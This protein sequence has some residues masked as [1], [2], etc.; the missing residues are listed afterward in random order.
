MKK[1]T[2]F[3]A[4]ILASALAK[5]QV[6]TLTNS[7]FAIKLTHGRVAGDGTGTCLA[8]HTAGDGT[9]TCLA[10]SKLLTFDHPKLLTSKQ[11]VA[12][13]K[14]ASQDKERE[15]ILEMLRENDTNE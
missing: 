4:T 10:D 7:R 1:I 15:Q 12:L 11:I 2:L 9:G 13:L 3:L 14:E 8:D 5:A 6:I